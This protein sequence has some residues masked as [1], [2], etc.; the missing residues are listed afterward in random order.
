MLSFQWPWMAL[1]LLVPLVM[2]LLKR[3][4]SYTSTDT[5]E[6]KMTLLHPDLINNFTTY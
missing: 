4:R 2:W 3:D 1:L 6:R 5:R